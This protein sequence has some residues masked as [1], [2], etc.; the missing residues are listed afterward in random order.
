MVKTIVRKDKLLY[1]KVVK[2]IT[3]LVFYVK[4]KMTIKKN[5]RE[6]IV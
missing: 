3:C 1:K 5:T 4:K 2:F 6:V